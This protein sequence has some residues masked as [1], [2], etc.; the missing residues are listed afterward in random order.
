MSNCLSTMWVSRKRAVAMV[1]PMQTISN[2]VPKIVTTSQRRAFR[3]EM[4]NVFIVSPFVP[5]AGVMRDWCRIEPGTCGLGNML[6]PSAAPPVVALHAY[7][8]D[9]DTD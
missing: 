4:G 3:S 9:A 8:P 2:K 7:R 1:A 5:T 6:A